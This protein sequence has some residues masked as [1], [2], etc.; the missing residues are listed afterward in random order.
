VLNQGRAI[1]GHMN[2][3]LHLFP[4]FA[5]LAVEGEVYNTKGVLCSCCTERTPLPSSRRKLT[6]RSLTVSPSHTSITSQHSS[7][8]E[9]SNTRFDLESYGLYL[10]GQILGLKP[11]LAGISERTQFLQPGVHYRPFPVDRVAVSWTCMQAMWQI[12]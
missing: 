6:R 7:C 1:E 4:R 11:P 9:F 8:L 10:D 5:L 3:T 2:T 12:G